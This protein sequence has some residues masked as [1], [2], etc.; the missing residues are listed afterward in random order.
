MPVARIIQTR[1]FI[2]SRL[3]KYLP[4]EYTTTIAITLPGVTGITV[5]FN[6]F[7]IQPAMP[8]NSITIV[9][10]KQATADKTLAMIYRFRSIACCSPGE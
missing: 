3:Y 4:D 7:V 8:D 1:N 2:R 5:F 9:K 6:E 10:F